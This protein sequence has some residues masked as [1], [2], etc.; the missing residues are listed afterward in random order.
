MGM[1]A[2]KGTRNRWRYQVQLRR[3]EFV[4][5]CRR[6]ADVVRGA[7]DAVT[8]SRKTCSQACGDWPPNEQT[9]HD[10]AAVNVLVPGPENRL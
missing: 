6:G 4:S 10:H 2:S 7:G 5:W 3:T 8:S 1:S 9:E